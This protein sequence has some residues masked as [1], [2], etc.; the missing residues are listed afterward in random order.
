[1]AS[2]EATTADQAPD[3]AARKRLF[4][5]FWSVA[6]GFWGWEADRRAWP[7]TIALLVIA[8]VQLFIQYRINVWNRELFDALEQ[9]NA[10]E[11]LYQA[12]IYFPLLIA[13]VLDRRLE[14]LRQNDDAAPVAGV[15]DQS[16]ARPL[17]A[18]RAATIISISSRAITTIRSIA[19]A[20]T[21][22]LP[23]RRPST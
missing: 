22:G 12:L 16:P 20:R 11:T 21:R 4:R 14:R 3:N 6:R 13:G 2:A 23:P 15:A 8:L 10:A 17:A 7:L 9:K 19:S 5:R 18:Q 1:M